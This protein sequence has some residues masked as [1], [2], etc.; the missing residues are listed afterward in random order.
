MGIAVVIGVGSIA[1]LG[2]TLARRFAREGLTVYLA[3][4]TEKKLNSVAEDIK[5]KG[6][7]AKPYVLDATSEQEVIG[8]FQHIANTEAAPLSLVAYN[9]DSNQRAPLL[10]T[11][12]E[13]FQQLWLQNTYAGF[14]IGREAVRQMLKH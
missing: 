7:I 4:R 1:G 11:S 2:A 3:G 6:G 5:T 14:L 10:E 13:M 8:L 12:S 9:V